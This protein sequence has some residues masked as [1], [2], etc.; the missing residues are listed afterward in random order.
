[1]INRPSEDVRASWSLHSECG[2]RYCDVGLPKGQLHLI[3]ISWKRILS[4]TDFRPATFPLHVHRHDEGVDLQQMYPMR[5]HQQVQL[6]QL[7][8]LSVSETMGYV[9][10]GSAS[11]TFRNCLLKLGN[12]LKPTGCK[13]N[14]PSYQLNAFHTSLLI[15]YHHFQR[16]CTWPVFVPCQQPLGL[17]LPFAALVSFPSSLTSWTSWAPLRSCPKPNPQRWKQIPGTHETSTQNQLQVA[18]KIPN[19]PLPHKTSTSR[20]VKVKLAKWLCCL[21]SSFCYIVMWATKKL[22]YFPIHWLFNRDPY[23][24]FIVI[25]LK[26]CSIIPYIFPTQLGALFSWLM[27]HMLHS[28]SWPESAFS[29]NMQIYFGASLAHEGQKWPLSDAFQ[30]ASTTS[31]RINHGQRSNYP[32]LALG[33][34]LCTR[35]YGAQFLLGR[36]SLPLAT[37][38]EKMKW[39]L[40]H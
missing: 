4:L 17:M 14:K 20:G 1:M 10:I 2:V 33:I 38:K 29:S 8:V 6:R 7:L 27:C 30:T 18:N 28:K 34:N 26:L 35:I 32:T 3:Y 40:S 24:G 12:I 31:T 23:Y 15:H 22:S 5:M 21:F 9:W 11:A 25:P 16:L 36:T 19:P 13:P 37:T 39:C